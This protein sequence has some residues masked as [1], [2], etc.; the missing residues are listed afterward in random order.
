MAASLPGA[1]PIMINNQAV[2][3]VEEVILDQPAAPGLETGSHAKATNAIL[4]SAT[5]GNASREPVTPMKV[6]GASSTFTYD[7]DLEVLDG[8]K[9]PKVGMCF[10]SE[11]EAYTFYNLYAKGKG[12]SIR[13]CHKKV[14]AD[15]TLSS[16]Y[17]V[18][19]KEGVKTNHPTHETVKEQATTRVK[20]SARV[21]FNISR[22]GIWN[23]QKAELSHNHHLVTPD[24]SHMLRSQRK[25]LDADRHIIKQMHTSGIRPFEIYNFYEQWYGDA[26]NVPFL[27][28]DN[29]NY[30]KTER[31]KYLESK[32]AQT[33][34]EYLKKKQAKDPSFFY[35][36]QFVQ[37]P[38][39]VGYCSSSRFF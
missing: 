10:Q 34:L 8:D 19:S 25:L 27:D 18:C 1:C 7:P 22:E 28:M 30:I 35:A 11:E 39:E 36:V 37:A 3:L 33:L 2:R 32:D 20:C 12:F 24:K 21:Q 14:R 13:K 23:I 6:A 17:F 4:T 5:L 31:E 26:E 38:R 15:K 16:K 9:V 29:N